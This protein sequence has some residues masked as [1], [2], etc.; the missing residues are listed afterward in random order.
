M[1]GVSNSCLTVSNACAVAV[2]QAIT[3][4]FTFLVFKKRIICLEKRIIDSFD[5]L[6]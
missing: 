2:L 5:L 1:I 3:I 6:P 4:A